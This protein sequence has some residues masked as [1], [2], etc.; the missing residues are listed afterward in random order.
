MES[1][2]ETNTYSMT[3]RMTAKGEFYGDFTVKAP[4]EETLRQRLNIAK[5]VFA[6]EVS[7]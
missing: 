4:D 5:R 3:I 6:G 1:H 7:R 2:D